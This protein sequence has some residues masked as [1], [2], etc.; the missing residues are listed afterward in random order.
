[1]LTKALEMHGSKTLISMNSSYHRTHKYD[2]TG[3]YRILKLKTQRQT[4]W[5][6]DTAVDGLFIFECLINKKQQWMERC[7]MGSE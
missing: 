6:P 2:E 3:V 7:Q 5:Q 1:M 4:I